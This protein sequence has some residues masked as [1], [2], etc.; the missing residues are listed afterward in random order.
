VV[1]G[2][3]D[4]VVEPGGSTPGIGARV[5]DFDSHDDIA[6]LRVP[7][8]TERP[9]RFSPNTGSGTPGAILGYPQD[10]PFDAEG[11][12]IGQTEVVST[13][14]AYGHGPVLRKITSL[15]GL[16]RP[17]NSGGPIVDPAGRVL[18]TVFAAI[19][20]GGTGGFAVPDSIVRTQLTRAEAHR[21]PVSTGPCAE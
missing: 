11:A 16:V 3:S 21:S 7:G 6:V 18:A 4:T 10:G 20:N 19:V 5:I 15:R 1:A 17:G 13:E 14:D 8:L 12:R 9:L 2:E